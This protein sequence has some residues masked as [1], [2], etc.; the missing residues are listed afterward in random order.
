MTPTPNI[1]ART[2]DIIV[3]GAGP[4]GQIAALSLARAGFQVALIGPDAGGDRRTT[5]LMR[6]ALDV[7]AKLGIS[8]FDDSVA[9]PLRTM[10]II[11]GT[12]RLVRSQPVTFRAS[13]IGEQEF[14]LNIPNVAL[15]SILGHAI[16]SEPG[17]ERFDALVGAWRPG[18][19][20][21]VAQLADGRTVAA[22]LVVAADGRNSPA[23]KAAG[24]SASLRT[25]PQVATVLNFGH[26]RDHGFVSTEFHTESGPFT[27]VPLP[28]RRSSLVWVVTPERADEL[29]GL[30]DEALSRLVEEQMQSM[31][32]AVTV[33]PGRQRFPLSVLSPATA[34]AN[35][36]MLVGEAAHVLPPI[37]AQGMNLGIRDVAELTRIVREH[38]SDPGAEPALSAYRKARRAD[39]LA[40]QSAVDLLNRSLLSDLLP[41]QLARSAGL[42]ALSAAAPLRSFVMREGLLPGSGWSGL[43]SLLREKVGRQQA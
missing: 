38:R 37:G 12:R 11:D 1:A 8:R 30:D 34:A 18:R 14:G 28:G 32:G 41:A 40:R 33:E 29:A 20:A 4:V 21:N 5:A 9:A 23:R 26:G 15:A 24:I 43:A 17:I 42:L 22:R 13:E 6:P 36:T 2:T 35:R 19:D 39:I 10:R 25:Y 16:A 31:L 3:A 27:Q 7:L